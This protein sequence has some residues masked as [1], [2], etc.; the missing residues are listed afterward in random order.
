MADEGWSYAIPHGASACSTTAPVTDNTD[1]AESATSTTTSTVFQPSLHDVMA[2]SSSSFLADPHMD[3]TPAYM[4]GRVATTSFNA[5]LQ[6]HGDAG[7]HFLLDQTPP[8]PHL[9]ARYDYDVDSTAP[10]AV[11]PRNATSLF[12]ESQF[13]GSATARSCG[14]V[15]AAAM[16][17]PFPQQEQPPILSQALVE[18][19]RL[20]S[21]VEGVQEACSSVTRRSS[22]P[23][24]PAAVAKKPRIETPSSLPTFKVRKEKLGDRIT[25]LQQL[26]SPFGKTDTASVLHEAIEYI[27]F[28]HD[29]VASL[30]SPYLRRGRPVQPQKQQG[31]CEAKKDLRSRG[32]CLVPVASTYTVANETAPEFWHPTFGGTFR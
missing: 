11:A 14:H 9:Q 26:V 31:S 6:L 27:K 16:M 17:K 7:G 32:L 10:A 12:A 5:L 15:P 8:R 13:S 30:S 20:K 1:A 21:D 3:W 2:S 18:S 4:G 28:L 19:K 24:S 29:Q 22:V 25:A 23:D